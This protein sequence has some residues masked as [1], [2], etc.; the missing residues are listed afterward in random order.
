MCLH[1]CCSI[2]EHLH[3]DLDLHCV[4]NCKCS[5]ICICIR[6]H[7]SP[8]RIFR[9]NVNLF[10]VS[11]YRKHVEQLVV[12]NANVNVPNPKP[13]QMTMP[14]PKPKPMPKSN[15]KPKPMPM[16]MPMPCQSQSPCHSFNKDAPRSRGPI[17]APTKCS[18]RRR[19]QQACQQ[20]S[21]LSKFAAHDQC[22]CSIAVE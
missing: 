11:T 16:P 9:A 15:P 21:Q 1:L 12:T 7:L 10:G 20:T 18:Q 14:K 2:D 3:L 19:Y 8:A 4:S 5:C 6:T 17:A 22:K 13:K